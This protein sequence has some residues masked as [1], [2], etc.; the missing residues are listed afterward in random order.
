MNSKT[1]VGGILAGIVSFLLGW[2][3]FGILL[4]DYY[5]RNMKNYEGLMK[6]SPEIWAIAVSNL[7]FGMLLAFVFQLAGIKTASR[8]FITAMVISLLTSVSLNLYMY[9]QFDLYAGSMLVTDVLVNAIFGGIVGAFLGRWL[10]RKA[11]VTGT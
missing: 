6:S 11:G 8:G 2:L 10:G 3:V 9:A 1:M 4:M 7:C 5:T